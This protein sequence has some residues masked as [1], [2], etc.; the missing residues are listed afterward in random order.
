MNFSYCL[1]DTSSS[2]ATTKRTINSQ[3]K[4]KKNAQLIKIV[5]ECLINPALYIKHLY[6]GLH[7]QQTQ[8]TFLFFFGFE[9]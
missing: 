7:L 3:K 9:D 1:I 2:L 6:I 4:K 8:W 5:N